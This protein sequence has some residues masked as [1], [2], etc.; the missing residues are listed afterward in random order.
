[1]TAFIEEDLAVLPDQRTPTPCRSPTVRFCRVFSRNGE[2]SAYVGSNQTLQGLTNSRS[3]QDSN[4]VASLEVEEDHG[5]RAMVQ[6]P[7]KA[8][9]GGISKVNFHKV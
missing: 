2:V 4:S 3:L 6:V 9:R 1:M 8:L 5:L 7:R